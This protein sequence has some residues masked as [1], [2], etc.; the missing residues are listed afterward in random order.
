MIQLMLWY[1][2]KKGHI[3]RLSLATAVLAQGDQYEMAATVV[4]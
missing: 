1:T 2:Y 4:C 3:F